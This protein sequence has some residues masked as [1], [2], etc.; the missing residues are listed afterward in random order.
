M[1][2]TMNKQTPNP[3]E[4]KHILQITHAVVGMFVR[5]MGYFGYFLQVQ[6]ETVINNSYNARLDSFS[7]R[8]IRGKILS[9]D[10]R[11]L[12][13]TAVQE[14]GSEVRTYPYQDLF[15]HA[16]GY[17]DH[18]KA[19]LEALANFYLL[20][21]HMN[22]AEQTL[23]Q[24]ADRKNLG[25]NVITTLDVDLQ[26]AAQAALGDRKGA[27]V[28]LEPD[29][30]KIL[31]MVSRPGFDPNTLGQEWET[32]IS[33]D[34]TQA[35]LLNRVSQGVYP[36]GSTFKIVTALEYIRA[37]SYTHLTLPTNSRV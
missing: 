6:S 24:L 15:A 10:G 22:L 28:A 17:S 11:V 14:D 30:G 33:G 29:T 21:S 34:N 12:A 4:N 37:V 16:V 8:I 35:Q 27:V 26:Q 2:R 7:D 23:N 31:A 32:L 3:G 1:R 20:S 5:L 19:G 9:N 18:G 13:E 25:D 36:P